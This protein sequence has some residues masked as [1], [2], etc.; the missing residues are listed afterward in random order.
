MISRIFAGLAAVFLVLAFA[1]MVLAPVDLS[2]VQGL[3]WLD[4]GLAAR[5]Q[6]VIRA[7]L[8]NATWVGVALPL[9]ARPVWLVPLGLGMVCVGMSA[10]FKAPG[11]AER[12]SRR[13]S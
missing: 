5:M 13:R 7:G 1:L 10:S 6:A 11:P 8:G 3:N 4:D 12:D 2:L 9:L